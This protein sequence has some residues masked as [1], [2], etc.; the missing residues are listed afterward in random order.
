MPPTGNELIQAFALEIVF[1]S[2]DLVRLEQQGPLGPVYGKCCLYCMYE[3]A[4]IFQ[5]LKAPPALIGPN[6]ERVCSK[7]HLKAH[8]VRFSI[9]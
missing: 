6:E 2:L 5:I 4:P 3:E 9:I 8:C 1:F 7:H